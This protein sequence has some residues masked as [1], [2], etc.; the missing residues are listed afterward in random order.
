MTAHEIPSSQVGVK[1]NK[2]Y[3]HI[4]TFQAADAIKLKEEIDQDIQQME[5]DQLLLLY[6]QLISY[7]HHIMLDYVKP[8]F[9]EQSQIQY[10]ELQKTIESTDSISGLSEYYFHLFRGMYEF[11]QN[12]YVSAISFYRKAEKLLSFVEDD[13]E[14]AEFHF[15]MSE[16]FYVMKQTHFSM[17]HAIQALETYMEHDFYRV[18][19]IQCHFVISGNYIDCKNYDKALEHL[20]EALRL[21]LLEGQPRLIGSALYNLGN[22]YSEKRELDEAARYFK[23]ALPVFE[24]HQLE[25]L[26]KALFSL[27]HTLFRLHDDQTALAYYE[28][29]MKIAKDRGDR[30][31]LEKY[32][33][34]Q[35]LY[36]ES[37]NLDLIHEVFHY[38]NEKSL[39][40]YIEDFAL[41][42]AV[43]TSAHEQYKEAAYFYEKAICM[44]EKLQKEECL[45]NI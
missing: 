20:D 38:M 40:V 19:R 36:L 43:Y 27:T 16:V 18:R 25:Q 3:K 35:A 45:Y 30:F 14:R 34:L 6:Y 1:I 21:A 42:A 11:D 12:N 41:E 26:P 8:D 2:W 10:S 29:G 39:Y 4:L 31:S 24:E 33:F 32:K 28:R 9:T 44:R 15:K 17:N 5:E 22:C 23:K 7:R 13:I 37:V